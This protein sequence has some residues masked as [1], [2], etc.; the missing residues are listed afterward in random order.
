[1]LFS[2]PSR[3]RR[4]GIAARP[5]HLPLEAGDTHRRA[6]RNRPRDGHRDLHG[7]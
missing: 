2:L 5:S 7:I 6:A 3:T 1:M 4:H